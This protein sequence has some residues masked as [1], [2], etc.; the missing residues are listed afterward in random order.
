[1]MPAPI[2]IL[3]SGYSPK[4]TIPDRVAQIRL[5]YP[6]G[7]MVAEELTMGCRPMRTI[8]PSV[9]LTHLHTWFN[10]IF[11]LIKEGMTTQPMEDTVS[12]A[13]SE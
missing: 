9:S 6:N 3:G 7:V 2:S 13:R 10:P 5:V 1:M 4:K 11:L 12:L 8:L